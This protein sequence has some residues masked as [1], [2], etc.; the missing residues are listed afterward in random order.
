MSI[1]LS[2]IK[3]IIPKKLFKKIQPTYHFFLSYLAAIFYGNPSNKLIV[4][5]ITGTSGKTSSVYLMAKALNE[6]GYKTGYTSTAMFSDGEKEWLNNKKMTMVGRFFT[7]KILSQMVKNNCQY[8]IIETTSEGIRQFRHRFIN[9]DILVFTGIYPEH[10]ESH[11]SFENY[12]KAKGQLFI[13]LKNCQ[14]KYLNNEN[15]VVKVKSNLSKI[16]LNRIKKSIIINGDDDEAFY[17]SSFWAEQKFYYFNKVRN[18]KDIF[19]VF[20]NNISVSLE[21]T[22]FDFVF[23][24]NHDGNFSGREINLKLW[25]EFN[26]WNSMP[27]LSLPFLLDIDLDKIIDGLEKVKSI[28]GRLEVVDVGQNFLPIVDYAYEPNAIKK[29]YDL[30]YF[31]KNKLLEGG[32][33]S[34]IIHI[35]G[36]AGGGRDKSRRDIMGQIAGEKADFVIISNED[37]YDE[38]PLDI[39]NQV[40]VG[41]KEA[42]KIEGM[43]L[44]RILD[45]REAIRKGLQLAKE[46]DLLIITGKGCEQA[47]CVADGQKIPWD[48]RLIVKEEIIKLANK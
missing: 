18:D 38:N 47:I 20:Y 32:Y 45:R 36:S 12:K 16:D 19:A 14:F 26:V 5:G 40:A 42:G 11:G 4:I 28:P 34:R 29:M 2:F 30:I 24:K 17:F 15:K 35:L 41:A 8:A 6:A 3:K 37:P 10:I 1:F 31:L 44:F 27:L 43:D 25:G 46:G 33:Q 21:G 23:R 7:Q 13:H 39:I 22:S 9:Y 48:D